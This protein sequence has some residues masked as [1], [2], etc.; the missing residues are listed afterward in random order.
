MTRCRVEGLPVQLVGGTVVGPLDHFLSLEVLELIDCDWDARTLLPPNLETLR[1]EVP[2][3]GSI[4]N[5]SVHDWAVSQL[6]SLQHV[7][8]M[9]MPYLDVAFLR[10]LLVHNQQNAAHP[11]LRTLEM[12]WNLLQTIQYNN[13]FPVLQLRDILVRH[14]RTLESLTINARGLPTAAV[15]YILQNCPALTS[16]TLSGRAIG[17]AS[18]DQI[19]RHVQQTGMGLRRLVVIHWD[20]VNSTPQ[21]RALLALM[22]QLGIEHEITRS[23]SPM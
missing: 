18:V 13:S 10:N 20:A 3:R 17:W 1:V 7:T 9:G 22:D 12:G 14:G 4:R 6:P 15:Y 23:A 2:T 8:I 19:V 11:G 16:L 21:I 5:A